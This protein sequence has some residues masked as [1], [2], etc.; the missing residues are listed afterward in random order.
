MKRKVLVISMIGIA[1]I[2][3]VFVYYAFFKRGE[4]RIAVFG[5]F[6]SKRFLSHKNT[7]YEALHMYTLDHPNTRLKPFEVDISYKASKD[8][9]AVKIKSIRE[10]GVGLIIAP[11]SSPITSMIAEIASR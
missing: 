4:M 3:A 2:A 8:E 9:I 6:S 1:V 5:P 7:Y 11:Y 10:K